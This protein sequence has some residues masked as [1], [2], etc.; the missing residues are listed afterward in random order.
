MGQFPGSYRWIDVSKNKEIE[1]ILKKAGLATEERQKEIQ[2]EINRQNRE[3]Q[4]SPITKMAK[5][6]GMKQLWEDGIIKIARG[7]TTYEELLRVCQ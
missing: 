6:K 7:V 1:E 4:E 5:E 2:D 3:K